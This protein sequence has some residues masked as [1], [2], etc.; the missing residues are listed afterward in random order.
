MTQRPDEPLRVALLHH[1]YGVS[2][3]SGAARVVGELADGLRAAGHHPCVLTSQPGLTR[4]FS[5]EGIPVVQV[6][7]LP[8]GMMRRRGF[9]G[10][11]THVPLT[12]KALVGAG[13][14]VAHAFSPQDA[15]AG[16][17]WRRR[18][19]RPTVFT[20]LE[21][22]TRERLADRRLRLWLLRH[23]V[24]EGSDMVIAPSVE[25]GEALWRWMALD[26]PVIDPRDAAAH[27]RA[28]RRLMAH[29][30]GS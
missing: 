6:G 30:S 10:P 26:A 4:R 18:V 21:T 27:E 28:Y 17:L 7:R 3:G 29:R 16:T 23:A 2:A 12:V 15:L 24:E 5:E 9:A 19:G 14:D 1:G 13:C 20:C 22:L 25:G 11:L 8:E